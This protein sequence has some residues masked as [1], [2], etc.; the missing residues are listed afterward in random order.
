MLFET[1]DLTFGYLDEI[2]LEGINVAFQ[3]GN[4]IGLIGANGCGKT[5]FLRLLLGDLTPTAGE[6]IRKRDLRTGVLYQDSALVDEG[7]VWEQMQSAFAEVI[8]AENRMRA[9]EETL[10]DLDEGSLAYKQAVDEHDRLDRYIASRDGYRR[11]V[12]IKT[13]LTGMGFGDRMDMEVAPLSGGEKTRLALC[14]LL[15]DD[16]DLLI[17]D[18]PTNHLDVATL[19]W[20]EGYLATYKGGLLIVSHDRYFLDKTVTTIW[21]MDGDITAYRG[22]YSKA[23]ML[24]EEALAAAVK[25]YDKQ[26]RQVSAMKEYAERNIVRASTSKSAK[27]RLHRLA[28]M[29]LMDKPVTYHRPPRFAFAIDEESN[30]EMLTVK[31]L[32]LVA[33][34]KSLIDS[35]SFAVL[36]GEKV[37]IVGPNGVGKSTLIKTLLGLVNNATDHYNR[38]PTAYSSACPDGAK[39]QR[40][41]NTAIKYGVDLSVSY[42]DQ[43]NLNLNP[44]ETVLGELWFR[45][46]AMTQT[47]ARSVLGAALFDA[48]DMDKRVSSL[49]GGERAKLG[50]C[51][52]ECERANLLYLDEPTNHL[53]L[54]ARE[55][56]EKAIKGYPGTVVFVSH[57]RYFVNAVAT[58]VLELTPSGGTKYEGGYD[59]YLAAKEAEKSP[60][61]A[62]TPTA[63]IQPKE[64]KGY[65]SKETKRYE[66]EKRNAISRIEK[67]LA[68]IEQRQQEIEAEMCSGVDYKRVAVLH[69][70]S[71]ALSQEEDALYTELDKWN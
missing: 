1:N 5:T 13:V 21:D 35:L 50:L 7:T 9:I 18:E 56:L 17:L 60:A 14:K 28:N 33:G 48:E 59:D 53:D 3:E 15:L 11:D 19:S 26:E 36:R 34:D 43:E 10:S 62:L 71:T 4:R 40:M 39:P 63:P 30:K 68:E 52:V 41:V 42:Y 25:A 47:Y 46:P 31:D 20:L 38:L 66:A 65:K 57:D 49:S 37:A 27:S 44:H 6:I 69:A 2:L 45:F 51:I 8:R 58:H 70:E 32:H 16:L 23:K 55:A 61:P 54:A 67:R 12:R 64:D 24:K 29:D 22:N